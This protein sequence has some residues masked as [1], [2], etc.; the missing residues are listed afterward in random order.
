MDNQPAAFHMPQK[1]VAQS[2]P[3]AG[4]LDQSGDIRHHKAG[5]AV[6]AH[7]P[8]YRGQRGKM[9]VGNLRLCGAHNRN[10]GG[11]SH[12]REAAQPHIG[13][14]LQFQLH[15]KALAGVA[16]PRKAGDLS[17]GRGKVLVAPAA[18]AAAGHH[19][20]LIPG[21]IRHHAT[22][23]RLPHHG[24]FRHLD[25][26]ALAGFAAA[27]GAAAVLAVFGGVFFLV[28][29]SDQAA[30]I[31]I[32]LEDHVSPSSAVAAV[33]A[34]RRHKFFPVEGNGAVAAV[35]RLD[36]NFRFIYKHFVP[37]FCHSPFS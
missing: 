22:G 26:K 36:G 8:Q 23:F 32:R 6:N 24:S 10:Q 31:G 29:E 9:I 7:H 16:G 4:A 15:L 17:G 3:L 11:F 33:R 19:H 1:L 18:L 21:K 5:L 20:R 37:R 14:Q 27:A 2:Q 35:P 30:H 34:A 28:A 25:D 12:I 13:Q